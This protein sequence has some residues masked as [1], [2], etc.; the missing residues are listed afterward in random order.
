MFLYYNSTRYLPSTLVKSN[1]HVVAKLACTVNLIWL[2]VF[3]RSRNSQNLHARLF[4]Y[5]TT[6]LAKKCKVRKRL[7]T[8][9]KF[10]SRLKI[11]NFVLFFIITSLTQETKS[12]IKNRHLRLS[13]IY[14]NIKRLKRFLS[15]ALACPFL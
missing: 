11:C 7:Q 5:T 4:P 1:S 13:F 10:L 14:T 8:E 9:I 2:F 15:R 3:G 12:V 6:C